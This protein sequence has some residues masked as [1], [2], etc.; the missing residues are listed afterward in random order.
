MTG[1]GG[2]AFLE[3][4]STSGDRVTPE[5]GKHTLKSSR[6]GTSFSTSIVSAGGIGNGGSGCWGL[7]AL[8]GRQPR[9]LGLGR[10]RGWCGGLGWTWIMWG[11]GD[12]GN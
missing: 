7:S 6:A 5:D 4:D 1:G 9:E 3:L 10:E 2:R 11:K 8:T 12:I